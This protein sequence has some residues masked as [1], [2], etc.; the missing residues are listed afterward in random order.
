MNDPERLRRAME[1]REKVAEWEAAG[2]R[3]PL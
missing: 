3:P 2:R 1:T